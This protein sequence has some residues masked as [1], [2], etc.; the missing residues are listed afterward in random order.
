MTQDYN[1]DPYYVDNIY[2]DLSIRCLEIWS[3]SEL[4]W[5]TGVVMDTETCSDAV[6]CAETR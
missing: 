2:N 4:N 1:D 5:E 3:H 6:S